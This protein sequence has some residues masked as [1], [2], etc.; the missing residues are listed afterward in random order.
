MKIVRRSCQ[1]IITFAQYYVILF[2][3]ELCLLQFTAK[4]YYFTDHD[5][6]NVIFFHS[7]RLN[8][9]ILFS[10]FLNKRK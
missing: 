4:N 2:F 8:K 6:E 1:A 9:F 10:E 3:S 7:D 5:K